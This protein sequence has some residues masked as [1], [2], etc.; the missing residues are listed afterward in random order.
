[1][2]VLPGAW[3]GV[4][5]G[6]GSGCYRGWGRNLPPALGC[7]SLGNVAHV[8]KW[9]RIGGMCWCL[10]LYCLVRWRLGEELPL[11]GLPGYCCFRAWLRV[12]AGNP[13]DTQGA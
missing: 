1:M 10:L 13:M 12:G 2:G 8:G 9:L 4:A 3:L 5:G 6:R 7:C 11:W